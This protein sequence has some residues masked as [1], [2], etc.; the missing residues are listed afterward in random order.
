MVSKRHVGV[1]ARHIA[2][3]AASSNLS[4]G[5]SQCSGQCPVLAR[6]CSNY[7]R[8][9]CL[10]GTIQTGPL[11]FKAARAVWPREARS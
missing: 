2:M 5:Y 1:Q 9:F 10:T 11:A 3:V 8:A 6:D 4:A 7:K